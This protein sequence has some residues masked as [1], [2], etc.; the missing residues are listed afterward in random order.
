MSKKIT[1]NSKVE[2]KEGNL[3]EEDDGSVWRHDGISWIKIWPI[4]SVSY[5]IHNLE[6][7]LKELISVLSKKS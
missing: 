4:D 1:L 2:P 3:M 7:A 6:I 5:R